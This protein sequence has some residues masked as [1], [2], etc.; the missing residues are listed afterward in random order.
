MKTCKPLFLGVLLDKREKTV[1]NF[2]LF[3]LSNS[4]QYMILSFSFRPDFR[5]GVRNSENRSKVIFFQLL[6]KRTLA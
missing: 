2:G 6:I 1:R 3:N 4:F 5:T